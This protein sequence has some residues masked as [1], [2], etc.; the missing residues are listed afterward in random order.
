MK[1]LKLYIIIS[2]VFTFS[3]F[4]QIVIDS[5]DIPHN[6]GTQ[7]T[8]NSADS[9]T[10]DLG[11]TGGPQ[12]WD[13][14]SQPMGS[15]NATLI[16]VEPSSTPYTDSFPGTNLVYS[17]PSDTVYQYYNLNSDCIISLGMGCASGTT[18]FLWKY[19]PLDS[20]PSP[21][22]YGNSHKFHYGFTEEISAGNYLEYSHYGVR[23]Y[24]AYGTVNIPYG[25]FD[26]LRIRTYDTYFF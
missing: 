11:S 26:C 2:L 1:L 8:K 3:L 23:E 25:S 24:D 14:T 5:D 9:V 13:F 4:G 17:S 10:V 21:Q 22:S 18:P 7:W 20:T 15:E 12:T 6:V 16:I 19:D